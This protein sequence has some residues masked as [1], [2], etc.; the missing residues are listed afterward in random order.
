MRLYSSCGLHGDVRNTLVRTPSSLYSICPSSG[1]ILIIPPSVPVPPSLIFH[2]LVHTPTF[3][4]VQSISQALVS[5]PVCSSCILNIFMSSSGV[6]NV[7]HNSASCTRRSALILLP[8]PLYE[9][10]GL[11]A[12]TA[13]PH[14]GGATTGVQH[15]APGHSWPWVEQTKGFKETVWLISC[16]PRSLPNVYIPWAWQ[17]G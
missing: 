15:R 6:F 4:Y 10:R 12:R 13:G 2:P 14:R 3:L 17:I 11:R 16:R 9:M 1:I 8:P 7:S 5:L